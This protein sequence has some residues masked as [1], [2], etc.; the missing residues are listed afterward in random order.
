MCIGVVRV[1]LSNAEESQHWSQLK[2]RVR[3]DVSLPVFP[4][5]PVFLSFF[6]SF[7]LFLSLFLS[8][9]LSF[10]LSFFLSFMFFSTLFVPASHTV[11]GQH[12]ALTHLTHTHTH[13]YIYICNNI[14]YLQYTY[15][16]TK[17]TQALQNTI[18]FYSSQL[19][20]RILWKA[21]PPN[22]TPMAG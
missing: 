22:E 1:M 19:A 20:S 16:E 7:L 17:A 15:N 13:I 2:H 9:F 21:H 4:V 5:F 12:P 14:F 6:L 8:F 18:F 10:I 3:T 11:D